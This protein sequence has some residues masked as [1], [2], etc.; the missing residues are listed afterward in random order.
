MPNRVNLF[1]S[2]H[3]SFIYVHILLFLSLWRTVT[4]MLLFVVSIIYSELLKKKSI[5]TYY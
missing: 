2:F 4:N 1:P 5:F 3:L